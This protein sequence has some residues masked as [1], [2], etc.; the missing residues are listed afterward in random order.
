MISRA[1]INPKFL[2]NFD[3]DLAFSDIFKK[4]EVFNKR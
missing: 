3:R 4:I 2:A 1:L